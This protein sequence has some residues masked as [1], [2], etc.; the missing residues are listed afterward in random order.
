[1]KKLL[2]ILLCL[3][4][5]VSFA[6]CGKK[7]QEPQEPEQ[8]NTVTETPEEPEAPV[9]ETP[10]EET[11]AEEAPEEEP[12]TE[13]PETEETDPAYADLLDKLA[14]L[15]EGATD[16]ELMLMNVE[17]PAENYEYT[18]F[19]PYIEGSHAVVSEP[20]IGSIAHSVALLQLPEDADA[21]AVAAEIEA[22]MDPRK[23]ICV[24]AE[25]S[26]VK[27]SGQYVLMVMSTQEAADAIAANFDAVFGA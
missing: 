16:G 12:E 24:E 6:A 2:A 10:A 1:M 19:I 8:N 14:Q 23:W 26:W 18:L 21:E 3:T 9:E 4:M 27:A 11:P 17:V 22:N 13:E 5:A 20:M 25:A 15:T 7:A